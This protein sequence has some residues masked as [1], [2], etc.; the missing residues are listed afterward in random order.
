[1]P[2]CP[3]EWVGSEVCRSWNSTNLSWTCWKFDVH[4]QVTENAVSS[5]SRFVDGSIVASSS[6]SQVWL[7]LGYASAL[8]SSPVSPPSTYPCQFDVHG[9]NNGSA[10]SPNLRL[11]V[12]LT[13]TNGI[14]W[15]PCP[16]S[17]AGGRRHEKK[18]GPKSFNP[19]S[20]LVSF[21]CIQWLLL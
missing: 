21:G 5:L 10:W 6:E 7:L 8:G 11:F 13:I 17:W 1:M 20:A 9:L 3:V 14:K 18:S 19:S 2:G 4:R 15:E 16:G 12:P